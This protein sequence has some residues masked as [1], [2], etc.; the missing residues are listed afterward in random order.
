MSQGEWYTRFDLF[1]TTSFVVQVVVGG[2]VE[3]EDLLDGLVDK[4]MKVEGM[5]IVEQEAQ[6]QMEYLQNI[7]MKM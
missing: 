4:G 2:E 7:V 6:I 1:L 5:L 3:L